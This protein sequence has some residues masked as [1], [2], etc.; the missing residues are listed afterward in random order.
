MAEEVR[1]DPQHTAS[2]Y[3]AYGER[4]SA[5]WKTGPRARMQ[6]EIHCHHL[7]ERVRAG[8]LVLDAGCGPGTFTKV[9][10]EH[11]ARVTC[12]DVSSVQL[13]ACKKYAPGAESYELGSIT[14]LG[15]FASQSFDVALALGGPLSYCFDRASQAL[16][17]LIR[18]TRP[19]GTIGLS[20]MNLFGS[21][22]RFFAAVIAVPADINRRVIATGD[23]PRNVNQGHEC[24]MFRVEEFGALLSEAGFRDI[25]MFATGWLVPNDEVEAPDPGT[26]EWS[27]LFDAELKSSAE[28]PGAGTHILAF[29]RAPE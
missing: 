22:H 11:G 19:G 16:A 8:D 9:L 23:L 7:R 27:M 2:Y 3:D 13:Q 24:H 5:R 20:V 18:V 21:L 28:S 25:E 17:E 29:A 1:F 26:D 6:F 15:R 14:D 4:E 10:L 12:L